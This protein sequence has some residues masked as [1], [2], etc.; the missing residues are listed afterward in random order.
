[1]KVS[2]GDE[3]FR[4][5]DLSTIWIIADVAEQDIVQIKVGA[6]ARVS[7]SCT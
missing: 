5:S 1:M 6:P 4:I 7:T 3:I 2:A